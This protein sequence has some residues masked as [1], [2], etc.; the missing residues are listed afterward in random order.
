MRVDGK[1]PLFEG[2]F[3][4]LGDNHHIM[5]GSNYLKT[6]NPRDPLPSLDEDDERDNDEFMIVFR[7]SDR[8]PLELTRRGEIPD[9]TCNSHKLDFNADPNHP[10]YRAFQPK[11]VGMTSFDSLFGLLKR[12]DTRGS[13]AGS[14]N[15]SQT[16]G[17]TNGCPKTRKVALVGV[18]LDCEYTNSFNSTE[19]ARDNVI[20]VI[21]SA[22][23]VYE[24][25]FNITLGLRNLTVFPAECPGHAPESAPFNAACN[26]D[27]GKKLDISKRLNLFSTWRGQQ[28]DDNAYWTLM[29]DCSTGSEVGLA[30]LG[31]LCVNKASGQAN[32]S[33]PDASS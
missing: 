32:S 2:A 18:T 21:N 19:S 1:K 22:S 31:Q 27:D 5:L 30:W 12:D 13:G 10:I 3:S 26:S 28:K 24:K 7:D 8:T 33:D 20:N 4:V 14:A 25:S 15:Y 29:S 9:N 6:R 16:I 11:H 23:Q 17:D